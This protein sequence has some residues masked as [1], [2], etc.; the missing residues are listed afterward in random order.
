VRIA[1]VTEWHDRVGGIEAYLEAVIPA[2]AA[3][4]EVGFWSA[5]A[6]RTG[7]QPMA[8]PP[9]VAMLADAGP[10]EA[11][12]ALTAFAPEVIFAHGLADPVVEAR[13][14]G[15][16]PTVAVEHT[17][18]GTC[19]SGSKTMA[20]PSI[21]PCHRR[22]GPACLALYLPRRCGGRS[23]VTMARLYRTQSRRLDTL[24][25]CRAIVTFSTHMKDEL[26]RHGLTQVVVIPPFV[27][28]GVIL[29]RATAVDGPVRRLLYLGRLETL[30]GPGRLIDALPLVAARLDAP[31]E[32][33]LAGEGSDRHVL[34]AQAAR[35][36]DPRVTVTFA[37]WQ[38][39]EGRARLLSRADALVMPSLLPEPFGL[40]GLEAAAAGVPT[41]AFASG[42]VREW[43]EDGETGCL[44]PAAGGRADLLADAIA[45]CI[46]DPA[47]RD[48]LAAAARAAATGW[49]VDRHLDALEPVL[50]AA[51]GRAPAVA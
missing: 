25:R 12:A 20:W 30:K 45:R 36:G 22:F 35:I 34:E 2:L 49:T 32:L 48:Q 33:T 9:R 18:H 19:I 4:H 6:A 10:E 42:G 17:Y 8:L 21:Q 44:A 27:T 50:T 13:L 14:L 39:A 15:L 28:P 26:V 38:D 51:S 37:G 7:R 47:V 3:R 29:P 40:V 1:V 23:P 24:A 5:N 41:V 31:V 16:A 46:G 11:A 43:L